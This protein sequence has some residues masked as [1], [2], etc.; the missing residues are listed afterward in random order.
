MTPSVGIIIY[1]ARLTMQRPFWCWLGW[2]W[3]IKFRTQP[4]KGRLIFLELTASLKRCPDTK[5][6][7]QLSQG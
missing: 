6:T 7:S 4:L 5:Q 2:G 3:E 1:Q